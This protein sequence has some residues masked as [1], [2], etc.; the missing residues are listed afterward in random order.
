MSVNIYILS[1]FHHIFF[2]SLVAVHFRADCFVKIACNEKKN[3][4]A[5]AFSNGFDQLYIHKCCEHL[6]TS[7]CNQKLITYFSTVCKQA[8][9]KE[10]ASLKQPSLF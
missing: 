4:V 2:T 10:L 1:H 7:L 5:L 8:W 3:Y 9:Q 6:N